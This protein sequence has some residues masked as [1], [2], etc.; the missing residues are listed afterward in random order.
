M[1]YEYK[2]VAAPEKVKRRRGAKSRT[3]RVALAMQDVL[4]E[5]ARNGW[6]YMRTDLV[7]IEERS[8]LFGRAQEVHRAVMVFRRGTQPVGRGAEPGAGRGRLFSRG[9]DG[10]GDDRTPPLTPGARVLHGGDDDTLPDA[11]QH[12]PE[13]APSETDGDFR[14]AAD[15]A[16]APSAAS[17]GERLRAP[18]GLG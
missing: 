3:D 14:L 18:N 13:Q 1:A 9:D 5:E 2:C 12:A 7:P 11:P 6:E 15:R 16:E 4:M 17:H 8:G 10:A